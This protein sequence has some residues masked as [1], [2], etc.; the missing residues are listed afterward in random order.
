MENKEE[1]ASVDQMMGTAEQSENG[2]RSSVV[3][4]DGGSLTLEQVEAVARGRAAVELST[5]P[6]VRGRIEGSHRFRAEVVASEVAVYGVTTGVG[7]SADRQVS[8]ARSAV[9]QQN[10][11]RKCGCGSGPL[12]P[13]DQARAA[14]LIRANCLAKGYSGVRILLIERLLDL[15]NLDFVPL[16]PEQG[17]VGASGDLV[18]GSYIAAV[19]TGERSVLH[20]GREISAG[21]AWSSVGMEPLVLEAKEGL[22]IINGTM[23]MAGIATL[24]LLD[25]ERLAG[26]CD[27]A[28]AMTCEALCAIDGPF[29]AF[30]GQLKPHAGLARS[31]AHLRHLLGG[32]QLVRPYAQVVGELQP[33]AEQGSRIL[34]TRIQDN[35]SLRCAPHCIGVLYD[36]TT[37]ARQWLEVEINSTT[38]N[39]IFEVETERVHSGGNFS[40]FHVGL[41]MDSLKTAVAS[42]ADQADRQL[43]LLVDEKFSNGLPANLSPDLDVAHP[44]RG[45]HHGFKGVQIASSAL[46]AEAQQRAM[47]MTVFSRSTE[48]NNQDKVSQAT[49]AARQARDIVELAQRCCAMHLLACCQAVE[50][51]GIGGLGRTRR[52]YEKIRQVSEFVDR[53][54]ALDADIGRVAGLIHSGQLLEDSES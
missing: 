18:P 20:G 13:E 12:L 36:T 15:L 45:I 27:V 37:W 42:V 7:D 3:T 11:V 41:A 21:E 30:F 32:S 33:L 17:S 19:L 39:P 6:E 9:L 48:C 34:P 51:R 8:A 2:V 5:E 16:I 46:A 35:Y 25:A 29:A 4:I 38:D 52:V 24:A 1:R 22:A 43:A 14:V 44:E 49:A 28:T 26:I 31:S 47:P 53:D 23:V 54:R 40:G 10:L 50:L